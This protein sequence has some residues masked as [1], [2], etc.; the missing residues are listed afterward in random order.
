MRKPCIV[1]A[2][3]DVELG[4]EHVRET[5][6]CDNIDCQEIFIKN[7]RFSKITLIKQ[8]KGVFQFKYVLKS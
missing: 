5:N 4:E 8:G 7:G 6:S 3:R 2:D 1:Q